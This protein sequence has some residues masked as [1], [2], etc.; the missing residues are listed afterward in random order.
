[1]YQSYID[2]Y[3]SGELTYSVEAAVYYNESTEFIEGN[4]TV[5]DLQSAG[6]PSYYSDSASID[7][8]ITLYQLISDPEEYG[9]ELEG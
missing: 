6:Q 3:E 4:I 5:Y 9:L 8:S 1:M 2:V 7:P